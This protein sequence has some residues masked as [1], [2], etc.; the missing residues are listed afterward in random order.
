MWRSSYAWMHC[1]FQSTRTAFKCQTHFWSFFFMQNAQLCLKHKDMAEKNNT[2]S[3]T[4]VLWNYPKTFGTF[5]MKGVETK[6]YS[7]HTPPAGTQTVLQHGFTSFTFP[8]RSNYQQPARVCGTWDSSPRR[9]TETHT[10][11]DTHIP[12]G[13]G[14]TEV[15]LQVN[16]QWPKKKKKKKTTCFWYLLLK[17]NNE[18]IHYHYIML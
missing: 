1:C 6:T 9:V 17:S 12:V 8:G 2:G 18:K 4:S 3:L 13:L 5:R 16:K 14:Y 11:C 7:T 15:Y 10:S